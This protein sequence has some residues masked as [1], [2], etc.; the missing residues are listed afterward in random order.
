[1]EE[2]FFFNLDLL[3]VIIGIVVVVAWLI[4]SLLGNFSEFNLSNIS[5]FVHSNT[6]EIVWN[7]ILD[8]I[9]LNLLEFGSIP[10]FLFEL[11]LSFF[12]FGLLIL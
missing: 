3:F 8:L 11:E 12:M 6:I 7:T 1:M 4:Y 9:L 2:I 5:I 10:D